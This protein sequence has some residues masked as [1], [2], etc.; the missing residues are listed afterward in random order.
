MNIGGCRA[1]SQPARGAFSYMRQNKTNCPIYRLLGVGRS[2]L[3]RAGVKALL[4]MRIFQRDLHTLAHHRS[5][6]LQGME[7]H[8][9]IDGV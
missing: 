5:G 6:P 3:Y 8:R 1:G 4:G 9:G 2:T 7:R